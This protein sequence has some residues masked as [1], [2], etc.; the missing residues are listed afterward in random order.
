MDTIKTGK[1]LILAIIITIIIVDIT[2]L[3]FTS[4][5]YVMKGM[6]D[7]VAYKLFRG[8]IRLIL[9]CI[10]MF[11]L[12]KGHKWAKWLTIVLLFIWGIVGFFAFF[13]NVF[14]ITL[15][16][17]GVLYIGFSLALIYSKSVT[18]FLKYQRGEVLPKSDL[19]E[20]NNNI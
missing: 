6:L 17:M 7:Y 4:L 12:Y 11:F 13:L 10:I 19:A 14:K 2:V 9:T 3:T 18:L 5:A 16:L 1:K 15:L 20:P 8:I